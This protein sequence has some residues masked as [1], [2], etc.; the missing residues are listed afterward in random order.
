MKAIVYTKYGSPDI[1]QFHQWLAWEKVR[2]KKN[3]HNRGGK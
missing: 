3:G 2:S 1:L